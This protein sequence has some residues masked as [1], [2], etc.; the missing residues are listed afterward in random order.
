MDWKI[1]GLIV[2]LELDRIIEVRTKYRGFV[3]LMGNQ[4]NILFC[5]KNAKEKMIDEDDYLGE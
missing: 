3:F 1:N 5:G 2:G 4:P